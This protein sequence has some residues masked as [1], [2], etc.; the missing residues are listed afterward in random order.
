MNFGRQIIHRITSTRARENDGTLDNMFQLKPPRGMIDV[1]LFG[2][3][4][5]NPPN[6]ATLPSLHCVDAHCEAGSRE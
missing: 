1:R 5:D 6:A 2:T 4:L 3:A